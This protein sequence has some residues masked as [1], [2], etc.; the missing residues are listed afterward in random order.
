MENQPM[1]NASKTQNQTE[2]KENMETKPRK[3]YDGSYAHGVVA[4]TDHVK[5]YS[6]YEKGLKRLNARREYLINEYRGIQTSYGNTDNVSRRAELLKQKASKEAQ[7]SAVT[8]VRSSLEG[9]K[10]EIKAKEVA[11]QQN[12]QFLT[13]DD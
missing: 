8:K 6:D 9:L 2:G 11:D 3:P 10:E 12:V 7:I 5:T 1:N 13:F 4:D